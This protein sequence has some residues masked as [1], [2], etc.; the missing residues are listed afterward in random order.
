MGLS[1]RL[2]LWSPQRELVVRGSFDER[3]QFAD[4]DGPLCLANDSAMTVDRERPW[5]RR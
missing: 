5:L 4:A 3:L 2:S 1:R